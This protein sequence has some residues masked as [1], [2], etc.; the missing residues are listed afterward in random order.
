MRSRK[1]RR[2]FMAVSP[3]AAGLAVIIRVFF[4]AFYCNGRKG[5]LQPDDIE[6]YYDRASICCAGGAQVVMMMGLWYNRRR[7]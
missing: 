6:W 2:V 3:Y 7:E 1:D 5:V 4:Y